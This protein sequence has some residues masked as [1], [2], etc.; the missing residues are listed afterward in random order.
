[1]SN[2]TIASLK[3]C[4]VRWRVLRGRVAVLGKVNVTTCLSAS[5][6][7][8]RAHVVDRCTAGETGH[9]GHAARR[10]SSSLHPDTCM[11][12]TQTIDDALSPTP[13]AR[14]LYT[15]SSTSAADAH[16]RTM[17]PRTISVTSEK[18]AP[19]VHRSVVWAWAVRAAHPRALRGGLEVGHDGSL[20]R[21][22][23]VVSGAPLQA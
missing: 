5:L 10:R 16:A 19:C 13:H 20:V 17:T 23:D 22:R 4:A 1:M 9:T 3:I 14:T 21:G 11:D 12:Y 15:L 2:F 6:R 18:H 8:V 7:F